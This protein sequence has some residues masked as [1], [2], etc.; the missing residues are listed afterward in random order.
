MNLFS[1]KKRESYNFDINDI[2]NDL[3]N[4]NALLSHENIKQIK[5]EFSRLIKSVLGSLFDLNQGY[6]YEEFI[7]YIDNLG[8]KIK[9]LDNKII[10]LKK[11]ITNMYNKKRKDEKIKEAISS[12]KHESNKVNIK[13][14]HL[15]TIKEILDEYNIRDKLS[16]LLNIVSDFDYG[17]KEIDQ[18]K[19]KNLINEFSDII[20]YFS[21]YKK[22][23]NKNNKKRFL[24]FIDKIFSRLNKRFKRNTIFTSEKIGT[25]I[26]DLINKA[27]VYI[28]N[29]DYESARKIYIDIFLSYYK[30]LDD[31]KVRY[32]DQIINIYNDIIQLKEQNKY[33]NLFLLNKDVNYQNKGS[34]NS[35]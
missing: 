8:T 31:K 15:I 20:S 2:L 6:T 5:E 22:I 9:E 29:E 17:N 24:I 34:E 27:S 7:Q 32:H 25:E 33:S 1:L 12:L 3:R 16:H 11:D 18:H 28:K 23:Q 4:L 10:N 13:Q 26:E 21:D 30:L 35:N 19:L 14:K